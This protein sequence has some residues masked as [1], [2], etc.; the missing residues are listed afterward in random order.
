MYV[1][2]Y[3]HAMVRVWWSEDNCQMWLSPFIMESV[4]QIWITRLGSRH[5]CQGVISLVHK[6]IFKGGKEIEMGATE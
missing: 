2:V 4:D 5:L 1:C 3:L 6:G